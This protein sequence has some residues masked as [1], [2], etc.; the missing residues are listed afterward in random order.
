[1]PDK[2][3]YT[4]NGQGQILVLLHGFCE[5]HE[6]WNKIAPL[7]ARDMKVI[8]PDL[9]GFGRSSLSSSHITID[10]VAEDVAVWLKGITAEKVFMMGH[11]LGGYITL[12]VAEKYPERLKA[13][14]LL[15]STA[16]S[17]DDAK[18]ENRT[19]TIEFL[20]KN[21][22]DI[23]LDSFIPGLFSDA[24]SSE[25]KA[26]VKEAREIAGK[27]T[28]AAMIAYTQ[29]MRNRPSRIHLLQKKNLP[30]FFVAGKKD[31]VIP[32]QKSKEQMQVIQNG[33]SFFLEK[34]AHMSM[35]E[36]PEELARLIKY[37]VNQHK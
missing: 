36:N 14:G 17:D 3:F 29:A 2:L 12:A 1:M 26:L 22:K 35:M 13:F 10:S 32:E 9:P 31:E 7:L 8:T 4:A 34:T 6:I 25:G 33:Q 20:E 27:T 23:F 5:T 24:R 28:L 19:K 16:F 15:N 30:V 11:S 21:G 37:F 18:K